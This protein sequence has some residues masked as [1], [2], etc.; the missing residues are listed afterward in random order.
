[1]ASVVLQALRG[2]SDPKPSLGRRRTATLLL[3]AT[4]TH[5]INPA[6]DPHLPY[7]PIRD[8]TPISLVATIP[9]VLITNPQT[10]IKTVQDLVRVGKFID[11]PCLHPAL[12]RLLVPPSRHPTD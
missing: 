12:W 5:G 6:L 7:D 9:H 3:G 1:M 4:T 2:L 11:R 8:F 10:N